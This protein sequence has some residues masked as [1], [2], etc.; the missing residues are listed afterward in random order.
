MDPEE[1][2]IEEEEEEEEDEE[3]V[4]LGGL[5]AHTLMTPEGDTVCGALLKIAETL[6]TQNKIMIKLLTHLTKKDS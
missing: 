6:Q 5:L 4:D 1:E 3:Y 2:E